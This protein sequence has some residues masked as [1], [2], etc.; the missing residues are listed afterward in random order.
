MSCLHGAEMKT[1]SELCQESKKKIQQQNIHLRG[2][3]F[4]NKYINEVLLPLITIL[5]ENYHCMTG[6]FQRDGLRGGFTTV[7]LLFQF[8]CAYIYLFTFYSYSY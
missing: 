5:N 1:W 6:L 2:F 8:E 4:N 3:H 7:V